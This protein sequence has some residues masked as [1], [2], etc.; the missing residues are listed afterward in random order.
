[1]VRICIL[2]VGEVGMT[3]DFERFQL[4][5][6]DIRWSGFGF[7]TA[8]SLNRHNFAE[9][10]LFQR[11]KGVRSSSLRIFVPGSG[12]K[13]VQSNYAWERPGRARMSKRPLAVSNCMR[14]VRFVYPRLP[15]HCYNCYNVPSIYVYMRLRLIVVL[16]YYDP[17]FNKLF[18]SLTS[19]RDAQKNFPWFK[20]N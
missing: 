14:A 11:C 17:V 18:F 13:E 6:S 5:F 9:Y 19:H 15:S 16:Y 4:D 3:S 10:L 20:T 1:L 8:F 12:S 7:I 2:S